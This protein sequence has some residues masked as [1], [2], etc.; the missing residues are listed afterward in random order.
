MVNSCFIKSG[1]LGGSE[2]SKS[3]ILDGKQLLI[4]NQVFRRLRDLKIGHFRWQTA[5]FIKS[6]YCLGG[7]ETSKSAILDG[8]QL[9]MSN[10]VF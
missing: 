9:F 8:K 3:A 4:S 2:A 1:V 5:V 7:P 6:V 10:Q